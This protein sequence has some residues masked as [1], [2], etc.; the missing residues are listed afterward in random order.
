MIR[1]F[2]LHIQ[3]RPAVWAHQDHQLGLLMPTSMPRRSEAGRTRDIFPS[4]PDYYVT[5]MVGARG[6]GLLSKSRELYADQ[7]ISAIP[8]GR[9]WGRWCSVAK[10]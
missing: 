3:A 7:A 2:F 9:R 1:Y 4:S 8:V 5:S 6:G 10:S